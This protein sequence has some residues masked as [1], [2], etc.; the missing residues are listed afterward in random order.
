MVTHTVKLLIRLGCE[1]GSVD[2]R[3][4]TANVRIGRGDDKSHYV[5]RM[6][7]VGL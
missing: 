7:G 6:I 3:L 2:G 5:Q 1:S 4:A